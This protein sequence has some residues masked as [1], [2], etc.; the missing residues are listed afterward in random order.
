VLS[1]LKDAG[2]EWVQID[3]PTLVE[4]RTEDELSLYQQAFAGLASQSR[5][6]KIMLQTYFE[7]LDGNWDTAMDLP[8][9]GIGLDFVRTP[10]NRELLRQKGFPADKVLG[11]GVVNGRNVWRSNLNDRLSLLEEIAGFVETDRIWVQP[12]CSL[13]HLPH[14]VRLE[15]TLDDDVKAI[16]AFADQRVEE[17]AILTKGL[18]VLGYAPE[19]ARR[20]AVALE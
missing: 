2:A 8:V 19:V 17:V 5:R 11:A 1:R 4:D 3:E 16:L 15:D 12:S 18:K 7:S 14:D 10:E 20:A 13:L 9:E 6:P